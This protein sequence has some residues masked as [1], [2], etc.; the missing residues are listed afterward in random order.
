M[1]PR[2]VLSRSGPISVNTVRPVNT[3]QPRIVVNNVG[4]M[5]NVIKNAYSTARRPFN[6][7][8]VANNSNFTKKVNIVKGTRVNT[9]RPK[10]VLSSI[11][12]NNRNVVKASACWVW[13]PEHKIL[14]HVSRNN[15]VS[16]SFKRFDSI[17]TL[18]LKDKGVI[19]S[20]CSRHMTGNRSYLTDYEEIDG[21]FV[22]F[23]GNSKG[24]KITGKD[25]KLTD[26]SIEKLIDL[27]VKVIRCNNETEFKNRVMNQFC[28]IKGIKREFSV[29]WTLQQN[30]VAEKKNRT[31]IEAA[32][33]MLADSKLP[34]TFWAEA[35]NTAC[36]V[37]NRVL[38]IK[39]HN[40]TPYEL[41]LGTKACD[42]AG[43]ARVETVP[44]KDY[45]L[46]PLWTQDPPF[47]S[48][49]KNSPDAGFK[50]SGEEEKKDA[51]DPG[52]ESGN[53]PE[54]KDSEDNAIDKNIVYGCA[55]DP[56]IHDLEEIGR[57]S[58][59]EDD[60][61]P[62]K[63][64][65]ALKYPSWIEA[66]QD[67]LLHFKLQQM[68]V[69]S[70]FLY[71]K[72][73]EEVYVCQPL[74]FED[75]DFPGRVYKV[76]K[77]L[78]GLHQAPRAWYETLS[79]YLLENRFQRGKIDKTFFI[80]R[81]QGDILIVQMS[82]MGELTFFLGLQVKQKEDGIFISQYKYVTEILKK[83][84]FSDVN[85]AS[86]LMETHKPLLKDADGEDIDEHMYRSMIGSLMYLTSLRPNITYL[87]C[88]SKLGL[89]YPKDSPFDLVA[90][91]DSEYAGA[92][93]DRKSTTGVKN[94]V[95]HS[96]TKH[97][98][99]KHHFIKN[100]NEKKLIQM[101]KIHTDKNVA[102]FLTKA[103]DKGI[104]VN[105]GDSKLMLLGINLLLLEKV[106]A[107]RHNL[108]LLVIVDFLNASLIKYALTVN[109]TIYTSCIKKF[110]ST[111]KAKIVNG[112]VQLQALVDATPRKFPVAARPLYYHHRC[113]VNDYPCEGPVWGCDRLVIRA[114]VIEN[115][116]MAASAIAI[117]SDS[118]N[119]SVGS[120]PSRVILFG[121]IPTVIPST[122]VVALE[123]STIAPVISSAAPV[124]E[125]T[126]VASPTGLCG[127]VP[128]SGSDSDSPDE[129]SSPEHISPLPAI[130]PFLCTDSSE[131]PDS[132]DGPPS[133]DP[134]VATVARWRSRVTA[135]P[136]SSFEFPIAPV[137]AP[138]G[139][140]RR[141]AILIRPEEAIPFGQP[142][143]THLNGPQSSSID[144]SERPLHSSSHSARP[145]RK[146]CRSLVDSV[147]LST[148]VMGSL[149]PTRADL[150]PP[151]K[152]F[153]DSYSS[154]ASV[155]ED[156]E[157]GPIETGVDIKLGI[158]DGDDV[159]DHVEDPRDVRDDT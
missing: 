141:S 47:S 94:L 7:I 132:S 16:M 45:I 65:Q 66:M 87:K 68:D 78:Y 118:S 21:G 42:D 81:D 155:E 89:W 39:P 30:G 145:S 86:T 105:A 12:G 93:L 54:G 67:E 76:E 143:R 139:I 28:E 25:F 32:R 83:F 108:L 61:E 110:W 130:S 77:A 79:T 90:Y 18:D 55:D 140:R 125:M 52:N 1:V 100:S 158:G 133:Q 44:G 116:I 154:E 129:M 70:A 84:G 146:R 104:G 91:T 147:P 80:K 34:I 101:I 40:K 106:N 122:S 95:F 6:K 2:T 19:D 58:D 74:R 10:A 137:T 120:P 37:Q 96:K 8:T 111:A 103:F 75:P 17:D 98:E 26:E 115:Q 51:K 38:F 121:D 124:V 136:S 50:P 41:F 3:V 92:R 69:K 35:V 119:E 131:A 85:T 27:R 46:L 60:V 24:G 88:Q 57:F 72:I 156:A 13:R 82:S 59:A 148:P 144:S 4:P 109:P 33:T 29:A 159:R 14:D 48:S 150:L 11:K 63:A 36:Y 128:Y 107:D 157:V 113:S 134:Y 123:T 127:L 151:R 114:K 71:G 135:R 23:G 64:I 152:R 49:P 56:N 102:D 15:G 99:I 53:L 138:P 149:A 126:L 31:L 142:Y 5:K 9:A 20:G 112:E 97:I 43:K 73:E 22:A 62:K 153:R 117:S